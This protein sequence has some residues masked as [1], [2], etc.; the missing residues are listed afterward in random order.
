M[1]LESLR[2]FYF[3]NISRQRIQQILHHGEGQLV[4][5]ILKESNQL[6][7]EEEKLMNLLYGVDS[8]PASAANRYQ[9]AALRLRISMEEVKKLEQVVMSRLPAWRPIEE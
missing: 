7:P 6:S 1:S 4:Y 5:W 3:K 2:Q 9:K 8:V